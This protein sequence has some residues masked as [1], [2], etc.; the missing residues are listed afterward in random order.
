MVI[1]SAQMLSTALQLS[2]HRA[3]NLYRTTH[4][5]HGCNV[6]V[7]TNRSHYLWLVEHYE[8]LCLEYLYR[9]DK[10]HFTHLMLP[11]PLFKEQATCIPDG[12]LRYFANHARH[13]GKG[14]DFTHLPVHEAY[15]RYLF[16]RWADQKR[17][18]ACTL[19]KQ[20]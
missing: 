17:A 1:E 9:Y 11:P 15:Q 16:A 2:G 19:G 7:R 20:I 4:A 6:W 13:I 3:K 18:V 10:F 14:L 8:A 12:R 5:N